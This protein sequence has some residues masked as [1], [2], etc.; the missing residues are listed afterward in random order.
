MITNLQRARESIAAQ[1]NDE[2]RMREE[3]QSLQQQVIRQERLAAIGVLVSGVAHEL[4]NPLQAI[5]GFAEL[6]Q[7][8]R[9]MPEHARADLTLIQKESARASAIIRNLSRFGRQISEPTPVR[10]RD[11]VASVMELRQ[12]KLEELGITIELDERSKS[13][14]MAIFTELQQVVLNF[15]INAEQAIVQAQSNDRHIIIRTGDRDGWAWIEVEDTGPGV[16]PE[17]EAKLFQPFY[18][19]KPVG[20]GT[21]LGLSVSYDII[22][23]HNGRIGYRRG[24]IRRRRVLF[25]AADRAGRPT[26][27]MTQ[28][29]YYSEPYRRSFD[30][31]VLAVD[32]VAGHT[33]VTLDQTAFYP[34]SGGQPFDTGTLGGAAVTDVID[35]E[36]GTIAHVVSGS[37]RI[38]EVVTGEIDWARRFD[39][40]QQHTG[41]HVLSAAF[42]RLCGARTE[43]FHMGQLSSTIDLAREVS[44][45]E[46]ARVEDDANRI[47][48]EDRPVT[49]R[50]ASAEEAAAMPLRKESARTGPL[51]LI[52][53]QDYDL[54]ACGGTHVERTGA[55][56]MIAIGGWEKFKG[57]SR[58]EFLCGGRALQR[59]RVWRGALSAVQKHLSVPPIEMAASIERMQE[60]A[61]AVQRTVRG[62]QEKLAA[63]EAQ[64]LAARAATHRRHAVDRGSARGLGSAGTEGDRRRGDRCSSRKRS[65]RSSHRQPPRRS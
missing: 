40:M 17:H 32:T 56:G 51:R 6:L 37:P 53:V 15:A 48:W 42:D 30:G 4:N 45:S 44:E 24:A 39:H 12:R 34:T 58:V 22:R 46:I 60:D 33:H 18:T 23:S 63:H 59:F 49:I 10:L 64:A 41:Q 13:L 36:D 55:I 50:F 3:L 57:G 1:V 25:R 5:L 2:R 16:A 47:V 11:V 29:I 28:R 7:M 54:S 21:G 61:K 19:T 27:V 35:R 43:S 52:D 14:V 9:D 31:K 38:G 26:H 8:K 62:F 20:E 65:S